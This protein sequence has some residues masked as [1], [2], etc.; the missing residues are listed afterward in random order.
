MG[1]KRIVPG[2]APASDAASY[3]PHYRVHSLMDSQPPA[4]CEA[5]NLFSL[6][7]S[8]ELKGLAYA[9]QDSNGFSLNP[10]KGTTATYPSLP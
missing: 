4:K 9:Q 1:I 3:Y 8:P 7:S 5:R 10:E 6:L 2:M